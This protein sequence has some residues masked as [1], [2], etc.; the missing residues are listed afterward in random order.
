M[1]LEDIDLLLSA[2][3]I[4]A[5]TLDIDKLLKLVLELAAQVVQAE[6]GSLLLLDEKTNELIFDVALGEAGKEL[7]TIRLKMGEGIAGWVAK[8]NKPLIV[9]DPA[10]DPRWTRRGDEK[11][12]FVTRSILCVPMVHQGKLLGVVQAINRKESRGFSEDDQSVLEAFAAQTAVAIQNARLF[13]S[14]REEKE[15]IE[16][17]VS[18]TVEGAV[19]SDSSGKFL[20]ANPS[21]HRFLGLGEKEIND[22]NFWQ[23]LNSFT[24]NPSVDSLRTS[25]L[26]LTPFEASRTE[27]KTLILSGVIKKIR[28]EKNELIGYLTCFR[29]VTAEKK[30]EKLKRDFLSLMSHKLKTPLVAITGYTP[31]LLEDEDL[32]KAGP[33]FKKAIQ[34]IH[35]QGLHLKQLVEKLISFSQIEA[36]E[37]TVEKKPHDVSKVMGEILTAM[38]TF[39]EEKKAGVTL[40]KSLNSLSSVFVDYDKFRETMKSLIENAAKFNP[41]PEKKILVSGKKENEMISL[42]VT[43]NGRGIPPEEFEKIFQKFYQIEESFTGQV[44]GAGLGLALV[45]RFVEAH[46]GTVRVESKIGEGSAFTVTF[47]AADKN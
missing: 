44:E 23:I 41:K 47:P 12:K 38:K 16:M 1:R 34:S 8:E 43:D 40:D 19:F 31:M 22:Q 4:L 5:S 32:I 37:M 6:T 18:Q 11:T 39:L 28:S 15:K 10:N 33:F 13:S 21:A 14:V 25:E 7:K 27:G 20:L 29:D 26:N 35:V 46:G 45:K 24:M 3:R 2:N 9:N 30:E 36:E 17:I 42:S